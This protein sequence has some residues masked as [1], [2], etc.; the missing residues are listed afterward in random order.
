M[1]YQSLDEISGPEWDKTFRTNIYSKFYLA[2]GGAASEA[3]QRDRQYQLDQR[4][5][6]EP[7]FAP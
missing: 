7:P 5:I 2:S 6:T 1:T 4:Q 3:R